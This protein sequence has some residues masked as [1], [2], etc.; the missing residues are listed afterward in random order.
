MTQNPQGQPLQK[1]GRLNADYA[2]PNPPD[3]EADRFGWEAVRTQLQTVRNYW[4]ITASKAGVPHAAPV[5]GIWIDTVFAFS[6]DPTSVKAKNFTENPNVVMHL[7]SGDEV[8]IFDGTVEVLESGMLQ[9]MFLDGYEPKYGLRPD[10]TNPG[11]GLYL[12]RPKVGRTWLEEAFV[13]SVSHWTFPDP[14]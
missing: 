1:K 14:A 6:T 8:I 9:T 3:W 12:F 4:I 13:E 2:G 5:W 11:H 10:P 7:E